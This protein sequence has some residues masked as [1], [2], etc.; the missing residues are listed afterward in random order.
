MHGSSNSGGH[1]ESNSPPRIEPSGLLHVQTLQDDVRR[2]D[3]QITSPIFEDIINWRKGNVPDEAQHEYKETLLHKLINTAA[4][5]VSALRDLEENLKE[6]KPL[7]NIRCSDTKETALLLAIW[8]ELEGVT[9]ELLQEGVDP[10]LEDDSGWLP[11]QAAS[12]VGNE[13]IIEALLSAGADAAKR[14]H[15]GQYP[16]DGAVRW[17]LKSQLMRQLVKPHEQSINKVYKESEWPLLNRAVYH[18]TESA[19]DLLL[20]VG[21]SLSMVDFEKWTPLMTAIRRNYPKIVAK[22]LRNLVGQAPKDIQ[23]AIDTPGLDG[24]TPIMLI[25]GGTVLD[26][27]AGNSLTASDIITDL[28]KLGPD[29]N[30]IDVEENTVLHHAMNAAAPRDENL[31]KCLIQLM[32]PERILQ[33]NIRGETAFDSCFDKDEDC[34]FSES[35]DLIQFLIEL[36]APDQTLQQAEEP[37]CWTVYRLERHTTALALFS[38]LKQAGKIRGNFDPHGCSLVEWAIHARLPR[39]LLTYL[40]AVGLYKK[41]DKDSPVGEDRERGLNLVRR[42]TAETQASL[43]WPSEPD[44][45]RRQAEQKSSDQSRDGDPDL[46]DLKDLEDILDYLYPEK[47][48]RRASPWAL[49]EQTEP[50]K[51]TSQRFPAAI[52]QNNFFKFR[53]VHEILYD[54]DQMENVR[55]TV[56]R[57]Q[58]FEYNPNPHKQASPHVSGVNFKVGPDFTWIHLPASN[59]AVKKVLKQMDCKD[60]AEKVASFL[61][62]SWIEIPDRTSTSRFMR[63][64][65]VVKDKSLPTDS[66]D[67]RVAKDISDEDMGWHRFQAN[68]ERQYDK[69]FFSQWI[70]GI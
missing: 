52:I 15:D 12:D 56:E 31:I 26:D 5:D 49:S 64:R 48:E 24:I 3:D 51:A 30:A 22:L 55:Q 11:L 47:A 27:G 41:G 40:R 50:M 38:K 33:S 61:R 10:E 68:E 21:A 67:R 29:I 59:D 6:W 54:S 39:V 35:R 19:I 13:T 60:E 20:E 53:N 63:P 2:D 42:L 32:R 1:S 57:L 4:D 17:P 23:S 9:A 45:Q 14:G 25:C 7:I 8:K 28:L 65:Y 69:G 18:G 44:R 36:F 46:K 16:L 70:T 66:K 58:K 34:P 43:P 62:S 37:L